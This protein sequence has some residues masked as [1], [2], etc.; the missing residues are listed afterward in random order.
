VVLPCQRNGQEKDAE[1]ISRNK[2][3]RGKTYG[4]TSRVFNQ[5]CINE[6]SAKKE[7][8]GEEQH[9]LC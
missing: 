2:I 8:K 6:N 7:D 3:S 4:M 1:R 5:S 9:K